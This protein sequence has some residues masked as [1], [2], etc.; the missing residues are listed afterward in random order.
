[1]SKRGKKREEDEALSEG[2][3]PQKKISKTGNDTDDSDNIV[4]CEVYLFTVLVV[5]L[6]THIFALVRE[7]ILLVGF[8]STDL[9][10]CF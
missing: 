7:I 4:V 3:E 5:V 8:F 9:S 6:S 1:M 2:D 10:D